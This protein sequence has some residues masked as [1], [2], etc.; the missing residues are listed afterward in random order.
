L[1]FSNYIVLSVIIHLIFIFLFLHLPEK[2]KKTPPP[3]FI[4]SLED[5][6]APKKTVSPPEPKPAF[7]VKKITPKKKIQPKREKHAAKKQ[8]ELPP[9]LK[10]TVPEKENIIPESLHGA[11]KKPEQPEPEK[12]ESDKKEK[13]T[14]HKSKKKQEGTTLP[15]EDK[16]KQKTAQELEPQKKELAKKTL[17]EKKVEPKTAPQKKKTAQK[18]PPEKSLKPKIQKKERTKKTPPE[19]VVKPKVEPQK[20]TETKEAEI[21]ETI[22]K[23]TVKKTDSQKKQ[24]ARTSPTDDRIKSKES[25]PPRKQKV[26]EPAGKKGLQ[27]SD[28]REKESDNR[29]KGEKSHESERVKLAQLLDDDTINNVALQSPHSKK[30][31]SNKKGDDNVVAFDTTEFHLVGYMPRLRQRIESIWRYPP[32]AAR[33]GLFGELYIRFTILRDGRLSEVE[34]VRTSGYKSLDDAAIQALKEGQP[35]WPLPK[36]W[37]HESLT[38]TGRFVYVAQG[39]YYIR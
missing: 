38:I 25:G 18:V 16:K 37:E 15:Q 23:K 6:P 35:Y 4:V 14:P 29:D 22:K 31:G 17:P 3:P 12:K 27:A 11:L 20:K 10:R 19:K 8:P 24:L 2:E 1:K 7:S 30:G 34:L 26:P 32:S 21:K 13:H 33:R 36:S 39:R 9:P 5:L 28:I